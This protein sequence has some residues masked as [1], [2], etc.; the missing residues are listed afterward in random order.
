MEEVAEAAQLTTSGVLLEQDLSYLLTGAA[1]GGSC[2][3]GAA[4]DLREPGWSRI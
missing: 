3:G 1:C 4:G 2:E